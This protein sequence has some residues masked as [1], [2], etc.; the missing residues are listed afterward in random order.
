M[1]FPLDKE[2]LTIYNVLVDE[3]LIR[4]AEQNQPNE[5][6]VVTQGTLAPYRIYGRS[7]S[8]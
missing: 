1:T 7:E 2:R 4:P 8:T 3:Q 5:E 6:S